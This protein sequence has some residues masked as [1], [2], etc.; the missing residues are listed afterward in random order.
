MLL[1]ALCT[2]LPSAYA[3]ITI[4]DIFTS[5]FYS[6]GDIVNLVVLVAAVRV[7]DFKCFKSELTV[8]CWFQVGPVLDITTKDGRPAH[9]LE[10]KLIDH[11]NRVINLILWDSMIQQFAQTWQPFSTGSASF[12]ISFQIGIINK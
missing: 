7:I 4:E 2:P 9:R 8:T 5:S 1:Q 11:T 12:H 3:Y 6:E 10:V